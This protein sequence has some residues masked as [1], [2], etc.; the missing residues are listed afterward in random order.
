M[1][2]LVKRA[3][4][5]AAET[6]MFARFVSLVERFHQQRTNLVQ[7]LTYHRIDDPRARPNLAPSTLSATPAVF[8]RQMAYLARRYRVV[9]IADVQAACEGG[10][11]LPHAAVL[12]TFD[13]AYE[14]F[15]ENAWPILQRYGLPAVLFVPS[16]Y[17]DHPDWTFWWDRLYQALRDAGAHHSLPAPWE[18]LPLASAKLRSL[19]H[20]RVIGWLK[21]LPHVQAMEWIARLVQRWQ[22]PPA[23]SHVLGWDALRRLA[24]RGLALGAHTRTHP[25]LHRVSAEVAYAE[26]AGSL[27]DLRREVG[28]IPP[29]FAYPGGY[30]D[31]ESLEAVRRAGFKL[32]FAGRRGVNCLDRPEPLRLRRNNIGSGTSQNVFRA[33]LLPWSI[34]LNRWRPVTGA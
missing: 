20:G 13:D 3:F 27:A 33:R 8:E 15:E 29:V 6:A 32:A 22:L 26:A 14:D 11:R 18:A 1:P 19:A 10:K 12:I 5:A 16:A 2:A 23:E 34:H 21:S 28:D 4:S 31:A 24:S 17:P 30:F 9:T 7:V 25:L